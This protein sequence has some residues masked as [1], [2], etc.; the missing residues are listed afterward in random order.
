MAEF[1]IER[2][3]AD[4]DWISSN[5]IHTIWSADS[6]FGMRKRDKEIAAYLA[7]AYHRNGYPRRLVSSTS[8]NSSRAVLDALSPLA[9]TP[10]FRGLTL[11]FQTH[12]EAALRDVKRQN[13]KHSAYY[14]MLDHARATDTRTYTEMILGLPGETLASFK[15]GLLVSIARNPHSSVIVYRCSVLPNAELASATDRARF[16]LSTAWLPDRA[17]PDLDPRFIESH[18][19][20]VGTNAMPE[21][22]WG[23]AVEYAWLVVLLHSL[24]LGH[25]ALLLLRHVMGLDYVAIF[26]GILS[27]LRQRPDCLLGAQLQHTQRAIA[28]FLTLRDPAYRPAPSEDLPWRADP[29]TSARLSRVKLADFSDRCAAE[30]TMLSFAVAQKLGHPIDV[31]VRDDL[32]LTLQHTTL[33][34]VQAFDQVLEFKTNLPEVLDAAGAGRSVA[35]K[36]RPTRYRISCS[37]DISSEAFQERIRDNS[38]LFIGLDPFPLHAEVDSARAEPQLV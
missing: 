37:E 38:D 19:I 3:F 22:D 17:S 35:I 9:R 15:E 23:E 28:Q 18:E 36:H 26:D 7:D 14:E 6:N 27:I 13:I 30:L 24:R 2:V 21:A 11:S 32:F 12:S 8:K 10:M 31:A 34:P 29:D 16:G 4:I 20:V 25:P 1:S 5:G 33:R